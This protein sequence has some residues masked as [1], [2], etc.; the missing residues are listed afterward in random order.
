MLSLML[1]LQNLGLERR[2]ILRYSQDFFNAITV[3]SYSRLVS[4]LL[5]LRLWR[6]NFLISLLN[7]KGISVFVQLSSEKLLNL[8]R[9]YFVALREIPVKSIKLQIQVY[10]VDGPVIFIW[11]VTDFDGNFVEV[12]I[13]FSPRKS[14]R[15]CCKIMY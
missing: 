3:C 15:L 5:I 12:V 8:D 10:Y 4:S 2:N 6:V 11:F 1:H 9:N 14:N 7:M 13:Q